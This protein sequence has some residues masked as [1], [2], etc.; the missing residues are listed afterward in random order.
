MTDNFTRL[1]RITRR[2]EKTPINTLK[3]KQRRRPPEDGSC[4]A[5]RYRMMLLGEPTAGD[6]TLSITWND[7]SVGIEEFVI[8]YNESRTSL[9]SKLLASEGMSDPEG[10]SLSFAADHGVVVDGGDFPFQPMTFRLI[11]NGKGGRP[12][13][14]MITKNNLTGGAYTRVRI[15]P[16]CCG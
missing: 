15:E 14:L 4:A 6:F 9:E 3:Q 11:S 2:I 12:L 16:I 7:E 13:E 8:D 1:S 5:Y 10:T